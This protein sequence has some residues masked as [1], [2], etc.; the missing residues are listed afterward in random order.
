V[1][2]HSPGDLP[3]LFTTGYQVTYA[4]GAA[5]VPFSRPALPGRTWAEWWNKVPEQKDAGGIAA[6]YVD[7]SAKYN[8]AMAKGGS[9]PHFIPPDFVPD[10]KTY[11]QLTPDGVL[12]P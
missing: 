7:N 10:G 11:R 6:F 4:P 3:L 2:T 8:N 9:V 12:P 5:A 1:T